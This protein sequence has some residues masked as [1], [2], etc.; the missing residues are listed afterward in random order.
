MKK[1][2]LAASLFIAVSSF[3]GT[4]NIAM[5]RTATEAAGRHI[6]PSQ[7]PAPVKVTFNTMFPTATNVQWEVE[8]EDGKT[9]YTA[10]FRVNG[11]KDKAQFRPNGT[12]IN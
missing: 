6:P 8:R 7:V 3:A 10:S 12:V 2:L 9:V 1:I 5:V 4:Y 11:Q